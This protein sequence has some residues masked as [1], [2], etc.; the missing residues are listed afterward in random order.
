MTTKLL[1]GKLPVNFEESDLKKSQNEGKD[2]IAR[3]GKKEGVYTLSSELLEKLQSPRFAPVWETNQELAFKPIK[4]FR[5]TDRGYFGDPSFDS[6]FK[7]TGARKK[8]LSP[9]LGLEIDGLQLSKLTPRQKD[10]LALLVEKK[11][12]I[13]FRNQD[14]KELSFEDLKKWGQYYGPLHVHNS[15]GAPLNEPDFHLIFDFR[16]KEGKNRFF[17]R[18]NSFITWHSDVTYESQ[19]A[20]ITALAML[21]TGEGGDTQFIDTIEAYDRLSPTM[22]V[23]LDGLQA[24]HTSK[25]QI[26]GAKSGGGIERKPIVHTI[27]P[28]V[29]YHPVLKKKALFVNG[30]VGGSLGGFT[31]K[32]L[33][34]KDEE[35]DALLRFLL[36]HL[37]T[38]LDAHIRASWDDKTVVVWDNRRV[39]HTATSDLEA[40]SIRHAFRVTPVAER[41]VANE[42][43]FNEWTPEKEKEL[44]K[45]TQEYLQ[46]TPEEYYNKFYSTK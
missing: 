46:L 23:F 28:V 9:K 15:S 1:F 18:H 33:G 24:V 5:H 41:P 17:D 36:G 12:V 38:C 19:P 26:E 39:I 32:I 44:I 22:K 13:V 35:S 21:Q 45:H 16:D 11:G 34:L 7:K 3:S 31:R 25:E 20:G 30:S 2:L 37:R 29:R 40:D 4:P 10:D 43:E 27:H 8:L 42:K 14:F 6:L